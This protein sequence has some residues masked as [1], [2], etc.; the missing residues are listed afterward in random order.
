MYD[1]VCA[2]TTGTALRFRQVTRA[3]CYMLRSRTG[4]AEAL[5][6]YSMYYTQPSCTFLQDTLDAAHI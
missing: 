3:A 2:M 6:L 4:K 1:S 5:G